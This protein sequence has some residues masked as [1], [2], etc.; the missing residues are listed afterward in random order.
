MR[1]IIEQAEGKLGVLKP[2]GG[3]REPTRPVGLR[4]PNARAGTLHTPAGGA[5]TGA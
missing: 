1:T 3:D 2:T 4:P 5:G